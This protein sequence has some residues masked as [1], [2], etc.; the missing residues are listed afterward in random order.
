MPN[1]LSIVGLG[2]VG[3]PLA[4]EFSKH[5]DVI[6]FD[7]NSQRI[8]ELEEG[9]DKTREIAAE[10]LQKSSITLTNDPNDITKANIHIVAVPT[11][12]DE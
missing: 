3:L 10:S 12:V 11:P 2:Y 9:L 7:I 4:I 6:G 5:L 1:T 8:K